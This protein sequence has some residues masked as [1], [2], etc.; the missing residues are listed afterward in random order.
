MVLLLQSL[1]TFPRSNMTT[2]Q[3]S[4]AVPVIS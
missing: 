3:S 2:F 1:F 4:I